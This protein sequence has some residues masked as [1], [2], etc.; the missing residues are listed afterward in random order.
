MAAPLTSR[1]VKVVIFLDAFASGL[2]ERKFGDANEDEMDRPLG[3]NGRTDLVFVMDWRPARK[4]EE[5]RT[6][7]IVLVDSD[8][9]KRRY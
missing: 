8:K 1:E 7:D 5:L 6:V 3:E 4:Q 9:L 2:G